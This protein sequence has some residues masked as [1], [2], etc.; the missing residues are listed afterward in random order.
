MQTINIALNIYTLN[1]LMAESRELA[2]E[3]HRDFLVS[4]YSDDMYDESL[5]M[6]QEKYEEELTEEEVVES[7]EINDYRFYSNGIMARTIHYC[8]DHP[9]SGDHVLIHNNVEYSIA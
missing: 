9:R 8:G 1:E 2:I 3:E 6:T 7:I 4:V 5:E